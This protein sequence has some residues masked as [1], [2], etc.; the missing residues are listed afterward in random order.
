[1]GGWIAL[2][3]ASQA[4]YAGKISGLVLVAPAINFLRPHYLLTYSS[5]Q[6]EDQTVPAVFCGAQLDLRT[7]EIFPKYSSYANTNLYFLQRWPRWAE[8]DKPSAF[9][10]RYW[11]TDIV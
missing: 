4:R 11:K 9:I 3:L 2:W 1:M 10:S 6:S 5:L 7:R 8:T